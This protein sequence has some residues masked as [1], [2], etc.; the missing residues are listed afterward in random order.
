MNVNLRLSMASEL[1]AVRQGIAPKQDLGVRGSVWVGDDEDAKNIF[2]LNCLTYEDEMIALAPAD[3]LR[4]NPHIIKK[5][6]RVGVVLARP[7][8][9]IVT[10]NMNR[11]GKA[12]ALWEKDRLEDIELDLAVYGCGPYVAH[13]MDLQA[14]CQPEGFGWTL[15]MKGAELDLERYS[16]KLACDIR[17]S[18]LPVAQ[19]NAT[20]T[21][22]IG[23]CL[24]GTVTEVLLQPEEMPGA[25]H[26]ATMTVLSAL[27]GLGA[28]D[29][30]LVQHEN[31]Q[32]VY[33]VVGAIER[34]AELGYFI[35]S[36]L[37]KP[38]TCVTRGTLIA[39]SSQGH[40]IFWPSNCYLALGPTTT[41]V[42]PGSSDP[43]FYVLRREEDIR[44]IVRLPSWALQ[45]S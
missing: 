23:L 31:K 21:E 44:R 36:L 13:T 18:E 27:A 38:F 22:P 26:T 7:E 40:S 37:L 12:M 2:V 43:L 39:K 4:R 8:R 35:D 34:D 6:W 10:D 20:R 11:V 15:D 17:I 33:T 42:R 28:L 24:P 16:S 3:F 14:N 19:K 25:I 45:L 29:E 5:G 30:K 9:R 41:E 32:A 1:E